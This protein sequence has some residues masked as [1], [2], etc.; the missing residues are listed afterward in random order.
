MNKELII[1]FDKDKAQQSLIFIPF[2]LAGLIFIFNMTFYLEKNYQAALGCCMGIVFAL[3]NYINRYIIAIITLLLTMSFFV[4]NALSF[5]L[6]IFIFVIQGSILLF[7]ITLSLG[8]FYFL[9]EI[10][11]DKPVAVLNQRGI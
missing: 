1:P 7:I 9:F 3:K 8:F 4:N 2:A 6:T 11:N 10:K 5:Y